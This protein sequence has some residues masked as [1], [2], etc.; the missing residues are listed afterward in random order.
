MLAPIK[1]FSRM[2]GFTL[3]E[4]MVAMTVGATMIGLATLTSVDLL[5]S[6]TAANEYRNI[7]ENARRSLAFM[8]RDFRSAT[9]LVSFASNDITISIL[10]STG[11]IDTVRYYLVS[12]NLTRRLTSGGTSTNITL[13]DHVTSISFERWTN[14]GQIASN[15]TNTYE[16]RAY[17]TIT[18]SGTFRKTTD[19]L[20]SRVLMRNK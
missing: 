1:I 13:T 17:L 4:A 15:T 6:F 10:D 18:N 11:G 3:V 14:P 8:T 19:L 16:L 7:H 9:N 5:K 20:Q 12:S 2:R